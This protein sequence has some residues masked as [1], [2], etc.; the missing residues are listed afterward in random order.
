MARR[1]RIS[2]EEW[3]E[4]ECRRLL[5]SA[6]KDIGDKRGSSRGEKKGVKEHNVRKRRVNRNAPIRVW[7][8]TKNPIP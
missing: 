2:K 1:L 5:A 4:K 7:A 8:E 6:W 3:E